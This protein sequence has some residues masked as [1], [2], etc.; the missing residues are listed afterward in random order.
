MSKFMALIIGLGLSTTQALAS[1]FAAPYNRALAVYA[2]SKEVADAR[3]HCY[4]LVDEKPKVILISSDY[5]R[6][7]Y[8]VTQICSLDNGR[9]LPTTTAIVTVDAGITRPP[10]TDVTLKLVD[11]HELEN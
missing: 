9:T 7:K 8:L 10:T 5:K 2:Q 6:S 3:F 1:D 4:R 11:L